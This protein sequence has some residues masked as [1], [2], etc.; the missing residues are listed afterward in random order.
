M[1][2]KCRRQTKP[3][4]IEKKGRRKKKNHAT[5]KH[6]RNISLITRLWLRLRVRIFYAIQSIQRGQRTT[7][8]SYVAQQKERTCIGPTFFLMY[9]HV[10][11]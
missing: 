2:K 3:N 6:L 10:Y 5:Q 8:V 11:A 1:R 7:I 4:Q 9:L